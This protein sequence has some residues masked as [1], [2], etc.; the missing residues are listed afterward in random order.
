MDKSNGTILDVEVLATPFEMPNG[1]ILVQGIANDISSRKR[2]ERKIM[3]S[4]K[5]FLI[6]EL[7]AGIVHEI[8]NPLTSINGFLQLLKAEFDYHHYFNIMENELGYIEKI[9]SELLYL[10]KPE[11]ENFNQECLYQILQ[12]VIFLFTHQAKKKEVTL[13]LEDKENHEI[14]IYGDRTKLKQVFINLIKNAIEASFVG[15]KIKST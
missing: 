1:E 14:L 8:R 13:L 7:A 15:G 5:L 9:A 2:V 10:S 11:K 12:D 6:G 4:E 3:Q